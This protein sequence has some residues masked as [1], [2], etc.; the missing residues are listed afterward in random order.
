GDVRENSLR[1]CNDS[2]WELVNLPHTWNKSDVADDTPGYYRGVGWYRKQLYID[3]SAKNKV[4]LLYFDGAN[5]VTELYVN[6]KLVGVHKGGY[7]R[8]SFDISRYIIPGAYNLIAIKV[9]NS[10][11]ESIPP[12][13]ADFT[14]F[15]GIY[16]NLYLQIKEK[17]GI[18]VADNA[19]D[20]VYIKNSAVSAQKAVINI[21]TLLDNGLNKSRRVEIIQTIIDP[22]GMEVQTSRKQLALAPNSVQTVY[23]N[24][25]AIADPLLWSPDTPQ[26]YSMKTVVRDVLTKKE[27]DRQLNI[28]GLRWFHFDPQHGFSINGR[29]IKLIG[30]NRHQCYLDK[31]NAL[32]DELHVE[33]IRL[34]KEMGGNFLRISHYPQDPLVLEMCDQLGIITSVEIPIINEITESESFLQN[35]LL[36]AKEMVK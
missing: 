24:R 18:S 33:D 22:A 25:I 6:E 30:T 9:N 34:L 17:T 13:S 26:L 16:R 27:L 12:L 23:N 36:M 10:H 21:Q 4:S 15:G 14:F 1:S 19:S 32:P 31:G 7:T 35:S 11:D 3:S 20:G 5:Q 28:F 8:F 29:H 2:K